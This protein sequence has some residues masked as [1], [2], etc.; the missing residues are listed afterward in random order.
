M[1]KGRRRGGERSDGLERVR[2]QNPTF[3]FRENLGHGIG[4]RN[5]PVGCVISS[6]V[7]HHVIVQ[8]SLS[9]DFRRL[10]FKGGSTSGP[11]FWPKQNGTEPMISHSSLCQFSN[12]A[13]AKHVC[14]RLEWSS[15]GP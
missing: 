9:T 1:E 2:R 4:S 14:W 11:M 15:Q 5:T 8:L 13:Y 7:A 12:F 3:L 6:R 10:K